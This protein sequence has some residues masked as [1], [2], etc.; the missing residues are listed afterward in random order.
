MPEAL[1][2]RQLPSHALQHVL[3]AGAHVLHAHKLPHT[4]SDVRLLY[5]RPILG[6][7][8]RCHRSSRSC[9]PASPCPI[10]AEVQGGW[11]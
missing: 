9:K 10:T 4:S 6:T 11:G 1:P 2:L 7:R 8:C 3:E 5:L